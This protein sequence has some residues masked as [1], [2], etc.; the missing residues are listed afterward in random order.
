MERRSLF[1]IR[2]DEMA[3]RDIFRKRR[4]KKPRGPD[5][6]AENKML[7]RGSLKESPEPESPDTAQI[8]FTGQETTKKLGLARKGGKQPPRS[9]SIFII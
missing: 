4:Q 7:L 8:L 6:A 1:F 5:N 9:P 3:I 2:E